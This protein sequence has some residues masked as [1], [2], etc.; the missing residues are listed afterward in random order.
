MKSI[1]RRATA[2]RG[3][4][5]VFFCIALPSFAQLAEP[6]KPPK[7]GRYYSAQKLSLG[8]KLPPLPANPFPELPVYPLDERN[9]AYDDREVDYE[10]LRSQAAS[11]SASATQS[12][13]RGAALDAL[14][15]CA[16]ELLVS[17]GSNSITVT[18]ANA[19]TG[20]VFDLFRTFELS[21]DSIGHSF[22]H[23][24]AKATNGQSLVFSNCPC[25]RV[26]YVLGCTNDTDGD[27]L[28]DAYERVLR[29]FL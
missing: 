29:K 18:V 14:G 6:P 22:W 15:D 13:D 27:G 25:D 19:A 17:W 23:W 26:F 2:L 24:V 12:F 5:V 16:S 7:Q 4:A 3:F 11:V 1:F 21:G 9:W 8:M 10:K 28:T 20:R